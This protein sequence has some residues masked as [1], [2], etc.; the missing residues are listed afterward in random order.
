MGNEVLR[1]LREAVLAAVVQRRVATVVLLVDRHA[2]LEQQLG[3]AA[4]VV[5]ASDVQQVVASLV[6]RTKNLHLLL[7]ESLHCV[8]AVVPHKGENDSV[9]PLEVGE[10]VVLL[11]LPVVVDVRRLRRHHEM[12]PSRARHQGVVRVHGLPNVWHRL[13]ASSVRIRADQQP[14]VA[15][16]PHL[17]LSEGVNVMLSG[18][19]LPGFHSA[20]LGRFH[21]SSQGCWQRRPALLVDRLRERRRLWPQDLPRQAEAANGRCCPWPLRSAGRVHPSDSA[22]DAVGDLLGQ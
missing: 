17:L 15:V 20:C 8:I 13:L 9:I 10:L 18:C 12:R 16:A 22:T 1:Q 21:A 6:A 7:D 4:V 3:N 14:H 19:W 5:L 11:E 2:V